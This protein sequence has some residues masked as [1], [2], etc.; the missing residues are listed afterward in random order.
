MIGLTAAE[1]TRQAEAKLAQ[2]DAAGAEA[3]L[4]HIGAAQSDAPEI[5]AAAGRLLLFRLQNHTAAFPLIER[6]LSAFPDDP[7][8]LQAHAYAAW[9]I[10]QRDPTATRALQSILR[11]IDRR[12]NDSGAYRMMGM[13]ALSRRNF[14]LAQLAFNKVASLGANVRTY[15]ALTDALLAGRE[16]A[17]FDLDGVTYRFELTT[18]TTQTIEA[19]AYH[20]TGMLTEINELRFLKDWVKPGGI[21]VEVGVLVG[22]HSAYFLRNFRPRKLLMF[23]ADP[24]L[25]SVIR[26]NAERNNAGSEI[27]VRTAFIGAGGTVEFGGERV[28][29]LPLADGVTEPVDFLKIDVD[30]A[31]TEALQGAAT[32]IETHHPFV[33][34]EVTPVTKTPVGNWFTARG[35]RLV[36]EIDHGAYCNLF[37]RHG[38]ATPR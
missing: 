2:G 12:P 6:A 22:N 38:V 28:P 27:V 34:I 21:I 14:A 1:L 3:L 13:I 16:E 37:W 23:D 33:M 20:C 31:E 10:D 32:L 29:V 24:A 7:D 5:A 35:Y 4:C 15:Q 36:G 30:G 26:R 18:S 25:A 11:L 8:L 17:A 19:G 9:I